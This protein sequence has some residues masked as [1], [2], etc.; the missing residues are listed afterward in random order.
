MNGDERIRKRRKRKRESKDKENLMF[1]SFVILL[2]SYLS[3][4]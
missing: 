2:T 3:W 1:S 4:V